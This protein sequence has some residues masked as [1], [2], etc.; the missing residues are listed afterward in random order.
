VSGYDVLMIL[1]GIVFVALWVA[2]LYA[3]NRLLQREN[4]DQD[5]LASATGSNHEAGPNHPIAPAA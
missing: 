3:M 1:W 5:L 2:F 4:R